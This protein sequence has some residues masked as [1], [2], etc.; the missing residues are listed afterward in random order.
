MRS[1]RLA[2]QGGYKLYG[3]HELFRRVRLHLGNTAPQVATWIELFTVE[4]AKQHIRRPVRIAAFQSSISEAM[5]IID[6]YTSAWAQGLCFT[7]YYIG[8][9]HI[10]V[11]GLRV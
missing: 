3:L 1:F 6:F 11:A 2:E 9:K 8:R 5:L 10:H 7:V 4:E